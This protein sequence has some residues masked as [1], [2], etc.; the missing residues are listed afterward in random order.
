MGAAKRKCPVVLCVGEMRVRG[1]KADHDVV[2][3]KTTYPY[4]INSMHVASVPFSHNQRGDLP[5]LG[6]MSSEFLR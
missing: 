4:G 1:G 5:Y 2:G 6:E 3:T